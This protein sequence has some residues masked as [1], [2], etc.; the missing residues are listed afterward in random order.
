MVGGFEVA[1]AGLFN[2]SVPDSEE[3]SDGR[4]E[5]RK[6]PAIDASLRQASRKGFQKR[7]P[8]FGGPR[9]FRH[10]DLHRADGW[11]L[12]LDGASDDS[13]VRRLFAICAPGLPGAVSA[14]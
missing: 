8:L 10:R 1:S 7:R 11:L 5:V 12:N 2:R 4:R 13:D 14:R 9:L 3:A 6:V